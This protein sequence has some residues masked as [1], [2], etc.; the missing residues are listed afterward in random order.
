[1]FQLTK[2]I[3]IKKIFINL[4]LILVISSV[5]GVCGFKP[6]CGNGEEE[7]RPV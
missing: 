3:G 6:E 2:F 7:Q 5:N 4:L 1:M